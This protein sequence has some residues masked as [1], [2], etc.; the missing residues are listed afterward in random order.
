M[1]TVREDPDDKA[2]ALQEACEGL[3]VAIVDYWLVSYRGGERVLDVLQGVFPQADIFM[4]V[5]GRG[6]TSERIRRHRI[7]TSFLQSIPLSKQAYQSLLPLM[8]MALEQFDVSG[9]NLMKSEESGPTK[10]VLTNPETCHIRNCH[11]PCA[12][13]M[14]PD[15]LRGG[16]IK[17]LFMPPLMNHIRNWDQLSAGRVDF[18][19]A[20]SI[21]GARRIRKYYR[22]EAPVIY[23]PVDLA[24]FSVADSAE[25]FYMVVSPLV[26]YKRLIWRWQ[27][28]VS[29][30][31]D[32]WQ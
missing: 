5:Y 20:S 10:G 7:R 6:Q 11:S 13:N 3:R 4:M 24:G 28:V 2:V 30:V 27:P 12:W 14:Y 29:F 21:N 9:Y 18:F 15:Y 16:W 23:P 22:R 19:V 31:S 1:R 17:R 25:D 26:E 32:W 8:P